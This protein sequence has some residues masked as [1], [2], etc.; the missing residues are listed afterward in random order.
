[1]DF[2]C[3]L[4]YFKLFYYI[5]AIIG[6]FALIAGIRT[7]Y[8]YRKQLYHTTISRCIDIYRNCYTNL[9]ENPTP[10]ICKRYVDFVNEELFYMQHG[11]IS[12]EVA[13]EWLYGIILHFPIFI[14]GKNGNPSNVASVIVENNLLKHFPRLEFAFK[15]RNEPNLTDIYNSKT[16]E[17][18]QTK[19]NL[20]R[21]ILKNVKNYKTN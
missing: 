7:F 3:I 18:T 13:R 12:D 16:G 11:F 21:E 20:V 1:M 17:I 4:Q 8:V 15:I 19:G 6:L 2:K 5:F 10:D 9:A 14:K